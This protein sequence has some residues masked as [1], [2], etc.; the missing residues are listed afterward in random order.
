ML[1]AVHSQAASNGRELEQL[2]NEED[3]TQLSGTRPRAAKPLFHRVLDFSIGSS[4]PSPVCTNT[5]LSPSANCS[6]Y[7]SGI[8]IYRPVSLPDP[9][10]LV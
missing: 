8:Y 5:S 2:E 4:Q 9:S 6:Y 3:R 1:F 7:A 10:R